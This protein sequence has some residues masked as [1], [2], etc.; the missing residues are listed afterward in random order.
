MS[1][2]IRQRQARVLTPSMFIAHDPQIP[3]RHDR[4]KVKVGSI[5]FLILIWVLSAKQ[6][7]P[8]PNSTGP[9]WWSV[10]R[11][12]HQSIEHHRTALREID[13]VRLQLGL[14]SRGVRVLHVRIRGESE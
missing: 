2:G 4:R 3:S 11:P 8:S 13:I 6:I 10:L 7:L 9:S 14:L 12:T 1:L 5:S